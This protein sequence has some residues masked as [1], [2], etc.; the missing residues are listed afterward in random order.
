MLDS[1]KHCEALVRAGD[2][3]RFLATLFAPERARRALYALYA[4]NLEVA[5]VRALAREPMPGEIRLQW[6]RDVFSAAGS[7]DVR[8]HPVA[9]ALTDT[10]VRY[11]LPLSAFIGL[12]EARTFDLYDDPI[13]TLE[14]LDA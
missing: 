6:W 8:G 13:A 4:F 10:I 7:G 11:R 5:Q 3:D 2:K 1:F 14:E 12:I 9:A